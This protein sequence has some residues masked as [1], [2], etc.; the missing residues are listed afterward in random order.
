[1]ASHGE[2]N[3]STA[4]L[5]LGTAT[6][7][8]DTARSLQTRR[9]GNAWYDSA[10]D[11]TDGLVI[12]GDATYGIDKVDAD[13]THSPFVEVSQADLDNSAANIL[14]QA[15]EDT[16]AQIT[17]V[18]N[19][20]TQTNQT[21]IDNK[22]AQDAV[23]RQQAETN[24]Q[25]EQN[26][27]DLAAASKRMTAMQEQADK[28]Y[29]T[30]I[31]AKTTADGR[32]RI[33]LQ[34][35]EP[36]H[37]GLVAGDLWYRTA[38]YWT[39]WTANPYKSAS[40]LADFY[41]RWV[42]EEY[43]S[44]SELVPISSRVV[45]VLIWD[46]TAFNEFN[47][48][49]SNIIASGTVTGNLIAAQSV[50]ADN[51][52][53]GCV[54]ADKL[55]AGSVGASKIVANAVTGD[56]ISA[57]ALFGKTIQGGVFRTSDG[58][59]IVNDTGIVLYDA[60]GKP[61]MTALTADGSLTLNGSV[62]SGGAI[63]GATITGGTIQ[64]S[65]AANRGV[66][67]TSG[68]IVG[69]GADG[70]VNTTIEA[71]TGTLRTNGSVLSG[72]AIGGA[73]ITGGE[74]QTAASGKRMRISTNSGNGVIEMLNDDTLI[75]DIRFIGDTVLIGRSENNQPTS[76]IVIDLKNMITLYGQEGIA[77]NSG[78]G[79]IIMNAYQSVVINAAKAGS[80][81]YLYVE[82]TSVRVQVGSV[83]ANVDP[84][85]LN[86]DYAT[87]QFCR[88]DGA[89]SL[90]NGDTYMKLFGKTGNLTAT[91][92]N[93]VITGLASGTYCVEAGMTTAEDSGSNIWR[94]LTIG[95]GGSAVKIGLGRGEY[96]TTGGYNMVN[97]SCLVKISETSD[98]IQVVAG[99]NKA[100][101]M[102]GNGTLAITRI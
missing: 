75:S 28:A 37:E 56:K 88:A 19:N 71:D 85:A 23:N 63:G 36:D 93:T 83:S 7:A 92:G 16:A 4:D 96:N 91:I 95:T 14:A 64:T 49:A 11:G 22:D 68:G 39:R 48:V 99:G 73:T 24:K 70:T 79:G 52:A 53:A 58:R 61:T 51:L 90:N 41:T 33:Y 3:P 69:Y 60:D 34:P 13:G 76:G 8:L 27:A 72:G 65:S 102:R 32:N 44:A 89:K 84:A 2:I 74:I 25:I 94:T 40:L 62:L 57:T 6:N 78:L 81:A 67:I 35:D 82:P 50:T 1:M 31:E 30:A 45:Q 9:T 54:N 55:M 101:T 47:L 20:L 97:A 59:L 21:I 26:K 98:W 100:A 80:K 12:G 18:N 66:K 5:I 29:D 42:G 86:H 77:L 38:P 43:R 15:K 46:G 87:Y 10:V 17:L